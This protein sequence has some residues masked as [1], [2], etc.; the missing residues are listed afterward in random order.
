[1]YMPYKKQSPKINL[2]TKKE[3]LISYAQAINEALTLMMKSDPS[4]LVVG[5]GV[6]DPKG[7]FGTTIGLREQF[8][9]ERVL[10]T[11]VSENGLTGICIGA[12]VAGM[13]P[14]LIHQ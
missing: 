12:A 11:P 10:D 14:G 9:S 1:M 13:R 6:P 5:E 2:S 3:R 7:I 4:V 8:G